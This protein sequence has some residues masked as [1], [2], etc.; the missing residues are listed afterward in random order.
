MRIVAV[1]VAM[2]LA[3]GGAIPGSG[4][5]TARAD[6]E[7][8]EI[9]ETNFPDPVF[10]AVISG[11]D[12]DKDGNG[13]LDAGELGSVINIYCEGMGVTS[14]KGVEYFVNLEGLWCKDNAIASMTFRTTRSS[15]ACGAPATCLP[16]WIFRLIRSWSGC[17]ATTVS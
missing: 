3:L 4:V 17:T 16:R 9:N 7:P 14:V 13:V 1:C 10:R 12:Y 15:T 8:V 5:G 2:L 11:P 6:G